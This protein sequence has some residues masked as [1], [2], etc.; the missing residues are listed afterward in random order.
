MPSSREVQQSSGRTRA[1]NW[2][3]HWSVRRARDE[4]LSENGFTVEE[5]EAPWTSGSLFGIPI[6]VP[7]T[8]AHARAI[9]LHDLHHVVTGYGTDM[10]GEGEISAWELRGGAT[11]AGLYVASIIFSGFLLGLLLAPRR[12]LRAW[13]AGGRAKTLFDASHPYED[14]L[15]QD[16]GELRVLLGVDRQGVAELPRALHARAPHSPIGARKSQAPS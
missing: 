5:Y 15:V 3:S 16:V 11:G 7:N 8:R 2:P 12:T 14:L 6:K 9:R 10:I 1:R 4:Y 13:R